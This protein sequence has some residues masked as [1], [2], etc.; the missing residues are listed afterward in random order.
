MR[1][2]R[3]GWA[4]ITAGVAAVVVAWV[5][6]SRALNAVAV[7][8]GVALAVGA[9]QLRLADRPSIDRSTPG[10]GFPG[11]TRTV[12]IEGTGSRGTIVSVVDSLSDGLAATDNAFD[13]T[14]PVERTYE[15]TLT[16][17]G[18][19]TI[20]PTT[21][22]MRDTLGLLAREDTDGNRT[23]VLVYPAVYDVAGSRQLAD[24][25]EQTRTPQRQA[26]D[27]LREYVPGDPLRDVAW[28]AS[29]KRPS[30]LVVVEFAGQETTGTV[31][32][33]ASA[34]RAGIDDAASALAST[35]LFL[36]DAGL[37]VGITVPDGRLEPDRGRRHRS[38]I[39][40][41]LAET[42]AGTVGD[43][44]WAGAD[45]RIVGTEEGVTVEIDGRTVDFETIR[46]D[47]GTATGAGSATGRLGPDSQEVAS[48]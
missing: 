3:R 4:A 8:A 15:L 13:G 19:H 46:T 39:L 37:E 10:A 24:I 23:S 40:E 14:L 25:V 42:D 17:R 31:E 16:E 38:A 30:E 9:I 5:F 11:E 27:R 22:R 12:T 44:R 7:T 2:T 21:V 28:K 43:Q 41:L 1:V 47:D 36:L 32:L 29:A 6:G 26:I 34:E 35:A 48:T 33:A 45:I 18:R 20:G